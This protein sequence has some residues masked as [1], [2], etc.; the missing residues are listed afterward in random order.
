MKLED[1]IAAGLTQ[2]QA[3]KVLKMHKDAIDGNY[4]PKATFEAERAKTKT[5][6]ETIA[7]RDKQIEE[8]GKFKGDNEQLTKKVEELTRQNE[9]SAKKHK[10][11]MEKKDQDVAIRAAIGDKVYC[12]DD[13]IPLLDMTKI[14]FKDGKVVAGLVEQMDEIK[15]TRPHYYKP[16]SQNHLPNGWNM[17]N[18]TP[19]QS[20]Q[21]D[22]PDSDAEFGKML[23]KQAQHSMEPQQKA[24]QIYFK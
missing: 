22:K 19:D 6:N 18:R 17:F 10:E 23:A 3:E 21:F 8:L 9:E 14:V 2:E 24:S 7:E 12:A 5:A 4:V 13:V 1:L 20:A 11:E 15:K 16:E